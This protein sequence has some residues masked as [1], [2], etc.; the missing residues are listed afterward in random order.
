[1][2]VA[3]FLERPSLWLDEASVALNIGRRSFTDLATTLDWSQLA[4]V[5]WLWLEKLLV[6]IFGMHEWALRAPALVAGIALP[7]LVWLAGRRLAGDPAAL[8]AT[9]LTVAGSG[10]LFYS[11]ETKPY[12]LDAVVGVVALIAALRLIEQRQVVRSW[13]RLGVIGTLAILASF[14]AILVLGA[15]GI[16]LM[17]DVFKRRDGRDLRHLVGWGVI[18]VTAFALPQM[19]LY[20]DGADMAGMARFWQP[21]MAHLGSPGLMGRASEAAH[22]V[23]AGLTTTSIW[24][25][26]EVFLL[27]IAIGAWDVGRRLGS[28]AGMMLIGPL[29]LTA[30][31]WAL[32]QFPIQ[33]RLTLFL[34]PIIALLFGAALVR[35]FHRWPG[36]WRPLGMVVCAALVLA[37]SV[38]ESMVGL[39]RRKPSGGRALVESVLSGTRAP[40]WLAS[41]SVSI[42][43]MYTTDWSDPDTARLDAYAAM[44]R[45]SGP[46]YR[47]NSERAATLPDELFTRAGGPYGLELHSRPSGLLADIEGAVGLPIA[48]W[49]PQ[50]SA[51]IAAVAGDGAWVMLSHLREPERDALLAGLRV[52]RLSVD[53]V[54]IEHRGLLLW[55]ADTART[56]D[57][58]SPD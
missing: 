14:P 35:L 12:E 3:Q 57:E 48:S 34:A 11:N 37:A 54:L 55:V 9:V 32:N 50:E 21:A 18:W 5:P 25:G 36:R 45:P 51:R 42:W 38:R 1:M 44:R 7:W 56:I 22:E 16:A 43:L 6:S 46:A 47:F 13:W 39:E 27:L 15:L 17:V 31:A 33:L 41:Y 10:L 49:G 24:P 4:P 52:R 20:R 30:L 28:T 29:V 2:R 19:L 58:P 8:I 40:I 53:T 23:F 26:S